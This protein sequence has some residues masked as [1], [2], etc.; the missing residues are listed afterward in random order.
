MEGPTRFFLNCNDGI[1]P[2]K[3]KSLV[4]K[5]GY[6]IMIGVDPGM[7]DR[8]SP[9]VVSTIRTCQSLGVYIHVYLVGVGMWSWSEGERQQ[10]REHARSVGIDTDKSNWHKGEWL[11][12]GWKEKVREQFNFYDSMGAY[13]CEIDN[14]DSA[15]GDNEPA[16]INFYKEFFKTLKKDGNTTKLMVKNFNEDML[17][18]LTKAIKNG[19]VPQEFLCEFGMFEDGT[20]D[21]SEQIRLCKAIGITAIT[22]EN[23]ITDTHSYGTVAA[24]IPRFQGE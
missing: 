7:G 9:E 13:S 11:T 12:W 8:P 21:P 5:Y 20:G 17:L 2:S 16:Y 15:L 19:S 18:L 4:K 14:I 1:A 6:D 22:P 3:V 23:G 24:G 10:I